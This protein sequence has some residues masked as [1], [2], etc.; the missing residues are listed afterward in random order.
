MPQL[1]RLA[2]MARPAR[3]LRGSRGGHA[4]TAFGTRMRPGMIPAGTDLF[5]LQ[6]PLGHE[7]ITTTTETYAH[8]LPDQNA[9]AGRALGGLTLNTQVRRGTLATVRLHRDPPKARRNCHLPCPTIERG[10]A[11]YT[12]AQAA[13][14]RPKL[15]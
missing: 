2:P 3:T 9:A 8:L 5:L 11:V 13:S 7:S 10:H 1:D 14:G 6:H 15:C 4:C 12:A